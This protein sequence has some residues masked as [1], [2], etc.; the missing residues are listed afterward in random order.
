MGSL[1]QS[2]SSRCLRRGA[3]VVRLVGM[4]PD[5]F[6]SP[7]TDSDRATDSYISVRRLPSR[8]PPR[9]GLGP[10]PS[11]IHRSIARRARPCATNGV[12]R[13]YASFSLSVLASRL[14]F[15][16]GAAI[17]GRGCGRDRHSGAPTSSRS[18]SAILSGEAFVNKLRG[19][20][21][22]PFPSPTPTALSLLITT[23]HYRVLT[24][25]NFCARRSILTTIKTVSGYHA[26]KL[27]R[28]QD[29]RS[30]AIISATSRPWD[31]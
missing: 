25:R 7:I 17:H 2:Y 26:A 1:P 28:Y 27:T 6:G 18:T 20:P 9:P 21:R 4:S 24:Y 11:P 15:T 29:M 14:C 5:I 10:S 16:C 30:T 12:V 3:V 13:L 22:A 31:A 8:A 19:R 23:T